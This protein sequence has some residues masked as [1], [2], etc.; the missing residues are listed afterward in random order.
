METADAIAAAAAGVEIP[1][2]PVVMSD[3]SVATP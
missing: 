2:D 3:V 1:S